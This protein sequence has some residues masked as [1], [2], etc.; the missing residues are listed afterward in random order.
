MAEVALALLDGGRDRAVLVALAGRVSGEVVATTRDDHLRRVQELAERHDLVVGVARTP[1][2]QHADLHALVGAEV[3]R[4]RGV[5]SWHGLPTLLTALAQ[6]AANGA[7][8]GAHLL[9]TAPDPG[10]RATPEEV[11]FLREVAE[12]IAGQVDPGAS[13]TIAWRGGT[14]TPTAADA[15]TSLVTVHGRRDVVEVPVAPATAADPQ[16]LAVAEQLGAR[17]TCVDTS[18]TVLRDALTAVVA[19]V[20][21]AE[22]PTLDAEPSTAGADPATSD[23]APSVTDDEPSAPDTDREG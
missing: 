4:Y 14:R 21:E 1:W 10:E 11:T 20:A 19:T 6:A 7:Q 22:L 5:V 23:A 16:L 13:T 8:A 2:P 9:V 15:L 3:A 12:A 17:L 18:R